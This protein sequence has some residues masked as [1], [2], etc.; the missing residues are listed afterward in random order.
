M[1]FSYNEL[2]CFY[3][4]I[5]EL[6]D[7]V[8]F[9][10]FEGQKCFLIRHDIDWDLSAAHE[11][12]K[13]E[14][15]FG[16]KATYFILINS[17]NY[18]VLSK[19]NRKL[20]LNIKSLN[21]EIGLHFDA[22][23]YVDDFNFHA[24]KEAKILGSIIGEKINSVALHNP[25]VNNLY[26]EMNSFNDAYSE[27]FFNPDFYLSDARYDFRG[28]IPLEFIKK[29]KENFLQINLHPI[30]F[31]EQGHENYVI[32]FNKMLEQRLVDFDQNQMKNSTYKK[33]RTNNEY[34]INLK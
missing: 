9:K 32:T 7:T 24:Q 6:G 25:S 17:D 21:H 10:D 12:A 19:S 30:H 22:S 13:I 1:I 4:R 8:L 11:M 15:K 14:N 2:S 20:I 26:P 3:K 31:S 27:V 16:I 33:N 23:L 5:N 29:I 18:N 34:S 28:K